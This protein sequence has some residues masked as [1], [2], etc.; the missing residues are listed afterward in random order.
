MRAVPTSSE[1]LLWSRLNARQLGVQFR[2]QVPWRSFILDFFAPALGL[3]VEVDGASH[4]N[5]AVPDARRDRRLQRARLRVLR[6]S[7]ELVLGDV[8]GAVELVRAAIKE[9][10]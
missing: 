3:V 5:R 10:S 1:R 4:A 8:E 6:L 7:A 9:S 2:R